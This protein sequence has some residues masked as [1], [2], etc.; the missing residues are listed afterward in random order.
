MP[1]MRHL[2]TAPLPSRQVDKAW[3]EWQNLPKVTSQAA[4][5]QSLHWLSYF[6]GS[7]TSQWILNM[8]LL[9]FEKRFGHTRSCTPTSYLEVAWLKI[10]ISSWGI[11]IHRNTC[12]FQEKLTHSLSHLSNNSKPIHIRSLG[13]GKQAR[14]VPYKPHPD[15]K[16]TKPKVHLDMECS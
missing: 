8:G 2:W 3:K 9:V 10:K 12:A 11:S 16:H 4:C 13:C 1:W 14:F 5:I 6:G 7:E 15:Y